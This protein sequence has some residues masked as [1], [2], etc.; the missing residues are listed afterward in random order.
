MEFN[1]RRF[2]AIAEI[3]KETRNVLGILQKEDSE[4]F[5]PGRTPENGGF[6]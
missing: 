2:D 4:E 3:Q 6:Y 5:K 1:G